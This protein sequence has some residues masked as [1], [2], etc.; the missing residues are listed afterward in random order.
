[1]YAAGATL[2][3]PLDSS[4]YIIAQLRCTA[5][6]SL[7][8]E[9]QLLASFVPNAVKTRAKVV[10]LVLSFGLLQKRMLAD[11]PELK[12]VFSPAHF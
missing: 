4:K 11:P 8:Q 10:G 9:F 6:R 1:M 12:G 2:E 7:M 5:Q 3:S